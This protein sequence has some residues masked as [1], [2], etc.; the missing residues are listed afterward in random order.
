MSAPAVPHASHRRPR[1]RLLVVTSSPEAREFASLARKHIDAV[2]ESPNF[3]DAIAE[4]GIASDRNPIIAVAFVAN[5]EGH[6]TAHM[7]QAIERVDVS[8]ASVLLYPRGE[9]HSAAAIAEGFEDTIPLPANPNDI[10]QVFSDL[11]MIDAPR[12]KND[13]PRGKNVDLA[14]LEIETTRRM[15]SERVVDSVIARARANAHAHPESPIENTTPTPEPISPQ[16]E[17]SRD[18]TTRSET[19]PDL[20]VMNFGERPSSGVSAPL[21]QP[22]LTTPH[23]SSARDANPSRETK[24]RTDATS[25]ARTDARSETRSDARSDARSDGRLDANL[26]AR[27]ESKPNTRSEANAGSQTEANFSAEQI[28]E[29]IHLKDRAL[30][31]AIKNAEKVQDV[32]LV[33]LRHAL[34]AKD[35]RF[36]S[37]A[38]PGEEHLIARE[39]EGVYEAL[40]RGKKLMHGSLLSRT[41]ESARLNAWASWLAEWLDHEED[42]R[43][44]HRLATVDEL[45]GALNRR[46]LT[47]MLPAILARARAE[48]RTISLMYF[49]IDDFK[50]YNDLHGHAAGDEV[51]RESIA[52]LRASIRGGDHIFR[53]GGDEFVV[54]FCDPDPPR[55]GGSGV[56]E[57]VEDIAERCR[58]AVRGSKFRLLTDA[59]PGPVTIS[60]GCAVFPWDVEAADASGLLALADTRS[61]EAKRLG[62]DQICFGPHRSRGGPTE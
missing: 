47:T 49:D 11:G 55:R 35:V 32:A 43:E 24:S 25:H 19:S 28:A 33:L 8:I 57:H 62:K 31:R 1:G 7:L 44:L 46:A 17:V 40:V 16:P 48:R 13:A 6:S 14:E 53:M 26:G 30:L 18:E 41:I 23:V 34:Q 2:S 56:P 4:I 52:A 42:H 60:A 27:I 51:L 54:V 5:C 39:R 61:L 20:G 38:R 21:Q 59:G 10:V 15:D 12:G 9:D 50:K 22:S 36:A 29:I 37:P 45:T 58:A 3:Y